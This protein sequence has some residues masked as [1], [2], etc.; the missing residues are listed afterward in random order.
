MPDDTHD[1][2]LVGDAG[3]C[4]L[5]NRYLRKSPL[6]NALSKEWSTALDVLRALL[7][8]TPAERL[9]AADA[10][11]LAVFAKKPRIC[12]RRARHFVGAAKRK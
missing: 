6:R 4:A 10:L 1:K 2:R 11:K 9:T 7:C 8:A 12:S 3:D 5:W